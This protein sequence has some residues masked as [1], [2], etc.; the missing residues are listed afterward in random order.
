MLETSSR[1]VALEEHGHATPIGP[2]ATGVESNYCCEL[3]QP[4][5]VPLWQTPWSSIVC[6]L[7]AACDECTTVA[8][9]TRAQSLA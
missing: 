3:W 1:I 2:V 6:D 9:A 8:P 5:K 7:H 4:L